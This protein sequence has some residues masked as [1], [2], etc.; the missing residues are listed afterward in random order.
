LEQK[1]QYDA[2]MQGIEEGG[3]SPDIGFMN[4]I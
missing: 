4:R 2:A 3:I 1:N